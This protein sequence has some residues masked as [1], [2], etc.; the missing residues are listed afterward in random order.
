MRIGCAAIAAA[1]APV[2]PNTNDAYG[3]YH[4]T[5]QI[6]GNKK[7]PLDEAPVYIIPTTNMMMGPPTGGCGVF[8]SSGVYQQD[9]VGGSCPKISQGDGGVGIVTNDGWAQLTTCRTS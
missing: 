3:G 5:L 8:Q 2:P 6:I 4:F 9:I 1:D 7:Y